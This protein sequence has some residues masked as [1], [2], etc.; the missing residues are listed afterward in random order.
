MIEIS[1]NKTIEKTFDEVA[2]DYDIN[3]Y[4]LITAK[5]MIENIPYKDNLNILDL[6]CGTGH[7]TILLSQKFRNSNI[8]AVDISTSMIETA[9]KKA[10]KYKLNNIIFKKEDVTKLSFKENDFDIITCGFGLFFYPNRTDT[11][12]N[13]MRIL[14]ENGIFI[15]SSFSQ[16]AFTPYSTIFEDKLEKEFNIKYPKESENFL[17]NKKE[18]EELVFSINYDKYETKK[19]NISKEISLNEWWEILNSA[20]YKGM[21]NQLSNKDLEIFKSNYLKELSSYC[22]EEKINLQTNTLITK[23]KKI[24]K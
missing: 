15:F 11:L 2:E 19:I 9:S 13:F 18:I 6:S 3:D 22:K 14:K 1:I 5:N 21:L 16:E 10:K 12:K 17:E 4:F 23:L 24:S 8:T 20:G 7:T